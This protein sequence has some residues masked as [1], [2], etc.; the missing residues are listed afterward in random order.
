M[1]IRQQTSMKSILNERRSR[2]GATGVS[3]LFAVV[4]STAS[5]AMDHAGEH[6][7]H[8]GEHKSMAESDAHAQHASMGKAKRQDNAGVVDLVLH[9]LEML[10]QNGKRLKFKSE[11][12]GEN[13]VVMDFVYTTCTTVCPVISA[14]FGNVQSKVGSR[15]GKDVTMVSITVDPTRDVPQRLKSYSNLHRV[16]PGWFW[17]T[18]QKMV[19][20]KV[21]QGLGAYTPAFEDHP[22]MVLVG[23]GRSGEWY[24]FYGF[25]SPDQITGKLEELTQRRQS[26][27]MNS[28]KGGS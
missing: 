14:I 21:L 1:M 5:G 19:V 26:L 27:S 2:W 8:A 28:S 11:V 15:L 9:D 4:L 23:D 25:P 13:L 20:D 10:D 3:L 12:I 22:A 17:L 7:S 24:R 18:G 16:K 6:K